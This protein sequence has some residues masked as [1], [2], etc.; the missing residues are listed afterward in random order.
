MNY[1]TY[2]LALLVT[3][4]TAFAQ[5]VGNDLPYRVREAPNYRFI[6]SSEY[7]DVVNHVVDK[8]EFY[9][10]LYQKEFS[11]VLDEDTVLGLASSHNQI[12]NGFATQYPRLWTLFYN[13]GPGVID[14][15]GIVS[16]VDVLLAHETV[17]LYQLN[18][19]HAIPGVMKKI[20]GGPGSPLGFLPPFTYMITPNVFTPTFLI[21]GNA[22]FNENRFG[23]GGRLYSAYY[24]AMFLQL[25]KS[26]KLTPTRIINDHIEWPFG[27]EKYVVGGYFNSYLA[28]TY[29]ADKTNKYFV[30][31][32]RKFFWPFLM[33][34]SFANTFGI[35]F[36]LAWEDF[37]DYY[38]DLAK[39]QKELT[40]DTVTES[41][42]TSPF[43]INGD[44]VSF[45]TST[46]QGL[47][48]LC[49]FHKTKRELKCE[50]TLLP[51]GRLFRHE[52]EWVTAS[53]QRSHPTEIRAG[54][55]SDGYSRIDGFDNQF[56]YAKKG[57]NIAYADSLK[58]FRET[59]V[60]K[61][62]RY[63][64]SMQSSPFMD[65]EGNLYYFKQDGDVRHLYRNERRLFRINGYSGRVVD[66][67]SNGNIF[68]TGATRAGTS[69]FRWD[70]STIYQ[71]LPSDRV[72][73]AKLLNNNRELLV[74]EITDNG[75]ETRVAK[76]SESVGRPVFY[77]YKYI[78]KK[79]IREH[80]QTQVDQAKNLDY[81]YSPL[82]EMEYNGFTPLINYIVPDGL[83]WAANFQF[84]DPLQKYLANLLLSDGGF[85]TYAAQFI[86]R[87]QAHR[88]QWLISALYDL[89]AFTQSTGPNEEDVEVIGRTGEVDVDLIFSYPII[90][91][92]LW[93]SSFSL[94]YSYE[95]FFSVDTSATF[96]DFRGTYKNSGV[97]ILDLNYGFSNLLDYESNRFIGLELG[98]KYE[99]L[100]GEWE[101]ATP[102][103]TAELATQ[104]DIF[105]Q[106]FLSASY[107]AA[108]SDGPRASINLDDDDGTISFDPTDFSSMDDGYLFRD[109]FDLHK[110]NAEIKQAFMVRQ[111]FSK[112]AIG[113]HRVAPF[114][115]YNEFY[116]NAFQTG[117]IGTLFHESYVG[118]DFEILLFHKFS[119]RFQVKD[120]DSSLGLNRQEYK[121][122]ASEDF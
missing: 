104:F 122:M 9:T 117:S 81:D 20:I 67:A 47:N 37:K 61:N 1:I 64:S 28:E 27:T 103:Y 44:V 25:L 50:K 10:K 41:Y 42:R 120:V 78:N 70:G 7:E 112:V 71:A 14:E 100:G 69:L 106:T 15:F 56:V 26:G 53:Y 77:D 11:W 45:M 24:R 22:M 109:Y 110:L 57:P 102:A 97:A 105:S 23:N 65:V 43:T 66:V 84:N 13:G 48:R 5:T 75:I 79:L 76:T 83:I 82:F 118:M 29:G 93:S 32:G 39:N 58:S 85:E 91:T 36:Y 8:N 52:G 73:D 119:L 92:P 107:K 12:T 89:D 49:Q 19:R 54:L 108:H 86:F 60:Y 16:W 72:F 63:V 51:F 115:G 4:S 2:I 96:S 40:G 87:S 80:D 121:L 17:H 111:Y 113:L 101:D 6:Y 3:S 68:F 114:Y 31:H 59:Q 95:S 90:R 30:N 38:E 98:Y 46:Y 62:G 99:G 18:A 21:E 35:S 88:L 33:N 94:G 34:S 74:A 55:F 116:G